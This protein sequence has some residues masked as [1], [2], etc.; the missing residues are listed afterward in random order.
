MVSEA[1]NTKDKV[2]R[3]Y[4]GLVK[5]VKCEKTATVQ[6]E[7]KKMHARYKKLIITHKNFLAHDENNQC[8]VG[9]TVR[10]VSVR[11]ISKSKT[12]LVKEILQKGESK[13]RS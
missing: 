3:S 8:E 12:W 2:I 9:D 1:K 7:F 11:P 5:N 10:I 13:E 6:V 4:T